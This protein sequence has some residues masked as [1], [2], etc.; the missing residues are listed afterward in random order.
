[1]VVIAENDPVN[2]GSNQCVSGVP[3][4]TR[5]DKGS[6]I[7]VIR[8]MPCDSPAKSGTAKDLTGWMR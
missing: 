3:I 2:T 7:Y 1:M 6:L 4:I 5:S 8:E